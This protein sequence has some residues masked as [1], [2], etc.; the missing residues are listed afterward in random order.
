MR[1]G[2]SRVFLLAALILLAGVLPAEEGVLYWMIDS[3]AT[4]TPEGGGDAVGMQTFFSTYEGAAEGSWFAARVRVTG[5]DIQ[6]DTF[7]NLY[8]GGGASLSGEDG[9]EFDT[10][11]GYW[12]AGV[13]AGNQSPLGVFGS[14][15]YSF[16]VEIGN[17]TD[18][19]W[20]TVA[21]S[22]ASTYSSL[23]NSIRQTF[24]LGPQNVVI[25]TP[26]S[27]TAVPEPSSGL[28]MAVGL[29]L[30]ALRR[31]RVKEA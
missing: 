22:A 24:D 8:A 6:S 25:W 1:I 5:G 13:P 15:E 4:V 28:L 12:G 31:G 2:L 20:T 10:V 11:G 27:F 19:S 30:L 29:A 9:L 21:Q 23:V 18:D 3:T 16:I 7:L 14:P 26:T 17:V